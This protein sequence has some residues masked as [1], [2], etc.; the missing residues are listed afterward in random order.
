MYLICFYVDYRLC[1]TWITNQQLW[2]YKVE[3]KLH[4][5]VRDQKK[6]KRLDTTALG[7]EGQAE[8]EEWLDRKT[9]P[10]LI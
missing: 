10:L 8:F 5:A 6:D 7:C 4:L 9:K 2:G 3:E 1:I